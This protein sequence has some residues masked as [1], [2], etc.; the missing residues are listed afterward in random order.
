[1]PTA[2]VLGASSDIGLAIVR[3]LA[4]H[5]Y[6]IQLAGRNRN[7]LQPIATDTTIRFNVKASVMTFDAANTSTHAD[8]FQG[9][10]PFPDITVY[11]IGYMSDSAEALGS[12]PETEKMLAAN[13]TGAVSIL[14]A[15]ASRYATE[16]KGI[17]VGISSV[18]GDRGRGSNFIYGSAKAAFTAYLA[19]LRNYLFPLGVHVL[20]VKPGFVYTR[21]TEN[22][23]LPPSLTATPSQVGTAVYKAIQK[24]KN[25]VY[26]KGIWRWIML[27]IRNIPESMFKKMKL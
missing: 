25:I 21:M 17:I 12:W 27:V 4:R 24:R 10:T 22:L 13:Y 14:N 20:T 23:T 8:F 19:G 5:G 9:L 3:E 2:L 15:I 6:D 26:V 11:V 16:K 7:A 1:M 18:A